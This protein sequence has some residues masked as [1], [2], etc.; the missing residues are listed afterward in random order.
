MLGTTNTSGMQMTCGATALAM[1][2]S[3]TRCTPLA[4]VRGWPSADTICT[5]SNELPGRSSTTRGQSRPT[6]MNMSLMPNSIEAAT[7]GSARMATVASTGAP[8]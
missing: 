1:E 3:G 8:S 2:V 5:R 4:M 7:S 6:P